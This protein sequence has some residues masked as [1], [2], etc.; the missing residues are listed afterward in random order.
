MN[1]LFIDPG[2]ESL[3]MIV[4]ND[5]GEIQDYKYVKTFAKDSLQARYLIIW[6]DLISLCRKHKV[7][8]IIF[9]IYT[10]R[11]DGT[12]KSKR[13][14][15]TKL[16]NGV[17]IGFAMSKNL[18]WE[19]YD[20]NEWMAIWSRVQLF[21]TVPDVP[22]EVRENEHLWDVYR[23]GYSITIKKRRENEHGK[24]QKRNIESRNKTQKKESARELF[25][26]REGER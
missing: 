24:T 13:G 5:L 25:E 11:T 3:G 17:I 14:Q 23:F 9:E 20:Y 8:E 22:D 19:R 26:K 21:G 15:N 7:R 10:F 4:L 2:V 16:T 6:K 1:R 18:P 12:G